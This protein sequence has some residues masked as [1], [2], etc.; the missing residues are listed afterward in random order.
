MDALSKEL[1]PEAMLYSPDVLMTGVGGLFFQHAS[2]SYAETVSMMECPPK[3]TKS[4]PGL[5]G[6]GALPL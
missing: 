3:D 4:M 2:N 1:R 5:L 6:S